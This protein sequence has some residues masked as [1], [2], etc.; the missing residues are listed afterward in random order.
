MHKAEKKIIAL[1]FFSGS[2]KMPVVAAAEYETPINKK[3]NPK[4]S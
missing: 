3:S 1:A 2:K 4:K